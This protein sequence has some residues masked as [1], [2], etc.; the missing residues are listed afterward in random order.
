MAWVKNLQN[1]IKELNPFLILPSLALSLHCH[2]L[3]LLTTTLSLETLATQRLLRLSLLRLWPLQRLL[4]TSVIKL[5]SFCQKLENFDNLI[6][7]S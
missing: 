5:T 7:T 2:Y 6:P 4:G 3:N 1:P